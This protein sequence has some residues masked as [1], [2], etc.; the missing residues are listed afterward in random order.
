MEKNHGVDSRGEGREEIVSESSSPFD[1]LPEE[2]I[3]KII[4]FTSPR[5]ALRGCHGFRKPFD[6]AWEK[7]LPTMDAFVKFD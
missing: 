1:A 7:F 5:D 4:Y 3:S 6:S 2:C